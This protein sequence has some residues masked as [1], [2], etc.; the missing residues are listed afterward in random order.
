MQKSEKTVKKETYSYKGWMNSDSRVKRSVAVYL[1]SL[2]G[3]FLVMLGLIPVFF[4][5]WLFIAPFVE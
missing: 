5:I 3:S 1:Y 2:F 4:V